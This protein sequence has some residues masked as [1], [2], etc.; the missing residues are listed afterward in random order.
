MRKF[1][2]KLIAA[3]ILPAASA[4]PTQARNPVSG[5]SATRKLASVI[6][7][8]V[9][10]VP[11]SFVYDGKQSRE[12]LPHWRQ[13]R[14]GREGKH[15]ATYT[16]PVTGLE[17]LREI[18]VFPGADAVEWVLRLRNT[19]T[20]DTPIIESIL[21]LDLRFAAAGTGKIILHYNRGSLGS[22]E[23]FLPSDQ[24][25]TS[26]K[27]I[28]L[29]H[30]MLEGTEHVGGQLP[31]FNLE[32][33]GGGLI[34]AIGWTGQWFFQAS[35]VSGRELALRS[36]QQFTHLKLHP[37][38]SLRTP[39]ILLLEWRVT[40]G[41][42]DISGHNQFRKLL[43]AHYVPRIDGKT[44]TPP[45]GSSTGLAYMYDVIAQKTGRNPLEVVSLLKPDEVEKAVGHLADDALNRV[46]EQNQLDFIQGIPLVGTDVEVYWLDAGWFEGEWPYGV[47]SWAPDPKKFPRGMRPLGDA[48]HAKGLKFLLWFE[49]GRVG[50][51]SLIHK[52]RPEWVLHRPNEGKL[53]GLF[54]YGKPKALQWM[55]NLLS[56]EIEDWG[57]DFYRHDSNICPLPFW[58]AA[59]GPDRQ[60]ITEA[61]WV[62]GL[63]LLWDEL[64]RR[65]P[66]LVIDNANWRITGPD[67]EV[68]SRSVGSL[69]RSETE[70]GG[71]P[72]PI[73]TQMQTAALTLW[74]PEHMGTVNG[75][76]PYTFRS[77]VTNG[78]GTGLDLRAKYFP[79]DQF[80][81]AI[82]EVKALR[83]YWLGDYY[84]LTDINLDE[85]AWCGWQ[86]DRQDLGAGF[87]VFFRRPK[88]DQS[89]LDAGLKGL[90]LKAN[91]K[92]TFA[93]TYDIRETRTLSGAH[94]AR[95]R[96][97]IDS[98]PGS[99][100]VRYKKAEG[101][102][103]RPR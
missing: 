12:L 4:V 7:Q 36:G 46:N 71:I 19:G 43:F 67:I 51:A 15:I 97:E 53:G 101:A 54:D 56:K 60:G 49:P 58:Q 3:L 20:V 29:I 31:F 26:E 47:G 74:A 5:E 50:S 16:D 57:I 13:T 37:G 6:Q 91:Y 24:E 35:R 23:D 100:L 95:L 73:A 94:L 90:D 96:V 2:L 79:L 30:Y 28:T 85:R 82:G 52:D 84:P 44:V 80:E 9:T 21:P 72:H 17:V 88:N 59:D 40:T 62:E 45:V 87:A 64:L 27:P 69:T 11:F 99:L 34:G 70:C 68:M 86:F 25:L 98:V 102:Q 77:G 65:H 89:T 22:V 42:V 81:K 33:Q 1:A 55:T 66:G 78:A 48:A 76:D 61:H 92:V 39:R 10:T 103:E 14:A 32:W 38:E 75:F 18:T 63:Y 41:C 93:E 83:P 8:V